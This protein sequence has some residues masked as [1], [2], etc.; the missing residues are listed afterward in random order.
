M[1]I[2]LDPN[3]HRRLSFE[4]SARRVGEPGVGRIVLSSHSLMRETMRKSVDN[5]WRPKV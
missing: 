1:K 4:V 5:S 2:T 3:M